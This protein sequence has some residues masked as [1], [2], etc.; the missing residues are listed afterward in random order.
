MEILIAAILIGVVIYLVI[1][2][3][4]NSHQQK[5]KSQ[6]LN[7]EVT[8]N[9][10]DDYEDPYLGANLNRRDNENEIFQISYPFFYALNDR[11]FLTN[12]NKELTPLADTLSEINNEDIQSAIKKLVE[13]DY[14]RTKSGLPKYLQMIPIEKFLRKNIFIEPDES[15]KETLLGSMTMKQLR[16][17][18][19]KIDITAARSKAKTVKRLMESSKDLG[20]DY[21][22]Y[23]M[24][25]PKVKKLYEIFDSYCLDQIDKSF[26]K[27]NIKIADIT[28]KLDKDSLQ[29]L[30]VVDNYKIQMYGYNSVIF[31]KNDK[32]LFRI[33]GFDLN[34]Y[35]KRAMLL[36]NGVT[37]LH[38]QKWLSRSKMS[39]I[40]LINEK[41]EVLFQKRLE[42]PDPNGLKNIPDE[43]FIYCSMQD[44]S[45]WVLNTKTF[46]NK[47][48]EN[49]EEKNIYSL[50]E[51]F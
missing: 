33:L 34:N 27:Y 15:H 16:K 8:T 10:R 19:D 48:L 32:P 9:R 24:I 22:Q 45:F 20:L 21:Q 43:N 30:E 50:L 11:T 31:Y 35:G 2:N 25:N 46:E 4:N 23:F 29:E 36:E 37:L 44:E 39:L 38:E 40:L 18:C 1:N 28:K 12:V 13:Q 5:N 17:K 14:F 51:E 26:D 47:F 6:E 49:P 42:N 41:K 7:I 3:N